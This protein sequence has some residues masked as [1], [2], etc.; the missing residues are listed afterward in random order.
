MG[1]AG[2]IVALVAAVAALTITPALL[3]LWGAKLARPGALSPGDP[4]DRWYRLARAVMRRP[5]PVAL[6]TAAVM[7]A[8]RCRR[9]GPV[10]P[11]Q[12][13]LGHPSG[14]ERPHGRRCAHP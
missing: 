2:A 9:W 3:A 5:G 7:L 11:R 14:P 1:I 13:Q 4:S 10:D 6:V 12:R 8:A